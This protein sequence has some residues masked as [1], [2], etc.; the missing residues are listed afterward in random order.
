MILC[1]SQNISVEVDVVYMDHNQM[2]YHKDLAQLQRSKL[3]SRDVLFAAT[4]GAGDVATS[5]VAIG[6]GKRS[7]NH[8]LIQLMIMPPLCEK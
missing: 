5:H 1:P 6:D 3:L 7:A 2:T 4:Q 8:L